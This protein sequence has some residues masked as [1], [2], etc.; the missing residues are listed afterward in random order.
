ML[1]LMASAIHL[2]YVTLR[3][4]LREAPVEHG[5]ALKA[6]PKL[7]LRWRHSPISN[8]TEERYSGLSMDP[9]PVENDQ[10]IPMVAGDR[11]RG[12]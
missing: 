2:N 6:R 8:P 11:R 1:A 4:M 7:I 9:L 12:H 5:S 10:E 3:S